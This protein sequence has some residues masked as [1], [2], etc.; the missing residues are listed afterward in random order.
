MKQPA[1]NKNVAKR[2]T[3]LLVRPLNRSV[4]KRFKQYH[5][6][7]ITQKENEET[8][9]IYWRWLIRQSFHLI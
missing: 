7:V 9:E 1:R 4:I 6:L 3:V 5:S 2:I 8:Q